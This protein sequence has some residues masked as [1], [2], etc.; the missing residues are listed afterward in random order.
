MKTVL[1]GAYGYTA[2]II[3]QLLN[4]QNIPFVAAGKN[5]TQLGELS[6]NYSCITGIKKIDLNSA[7]DVADL[8]REYDLIINTAGPFTE[9]SAQLVKQIADAKNKVYLDITGE[10]SF[11]KESYEHNHQK[12]KKNNTLIIH[13]CAFESLV[14]DLAIKHIENEKGVIRD[15]FTFY[16]FSKSK[17]S[18]GTKI[19]MK[20]SKYRSLYG[21]DNRNWTTVNNDDTIKV[22]IPSEGSLVGVPYPLP[23]VAYAKWYG[24]HNT[25]SYLLMSREEAAYTN[26]KVSNKKDIREELEALKERKKPGPTKE[27][28]E[29][30]SCEIY[31]H[32]SLKDQ[33]FVY[34]IT[35]HDMYLATAKSIVLAVEKLLS[36]G[37]KMPG[38]CPPSSLFKEEEKETLEQLGFT[39]QESGISILSESVR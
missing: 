20:L 15:L 10:I 27:K 26:L 29:L 12:A 13:G 1:I 17:P 16:R 5:V 32:C 31:L 4:E 14:V 39:L 24:Y 28:R 21:L 34:S 9:E 25:M 8:V 7:S 23:E 6:T 2:T 19:T 22:D 37:V 18:P 36:E 33:E 38:V 35:G 30:Q 3:C 11:V